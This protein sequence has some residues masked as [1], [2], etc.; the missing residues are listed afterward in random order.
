[1]N[2][3]PS[4]WEA[5]A[6]P[7][8]YFRKDKSILLSLPAVFNGRG[9]KVAAQGK[10]GL[11]LK[12][13]LLSLALLLIAASCRAQQTPPQI[14][15]VDAMP[16]IDPGT[17]PQTP[18]LSLDFLVGAWPRPAW[19][20]RPFRTLGSAETG[21]PALR[22]FQSNLVAMSPGGPANLGYLYCCSYAPRWNEALG[23][24]TVHVRVAFKSKVW[25]KNTKLNF[26]GELPSPFDTSPIASALPFEV[27]WEPLP[28]KGFPDAQL[29]SPHPYLW[30][31]WVHVFRHPA[32]ENQRYPYEA[33]VML[34]GRRAKKRQSTQSLG[35][36]LDEMGTE[37][38]I[39]QGGWGF[40]GG[41][42]NPDSNTGDFEFAENP[43]E[44]TLWR[45][46]WD[47]GVAN[48]NANEFL[49]QN[50]EYGDREPIV[51]TVPVKR[52]GV[53]L[54]G[55]IPPHDWKIEPPSPA[56]N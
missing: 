15:I 40:M 37:V 14:R 39:Q 20:G 5:D 50:I 23:L 1:M 17:I 31:K 18:L 16:T 54:E 33:E 4:A 6:L 53:T 10:I 51:L 11:M 9:K 55:D 19:W 27:Q 38:V 12:P 21:L 7:L 26:R 42:H 45:M 22:D 43:L 41:F 49:Q 46:G 56:S 29:I 25:P 36:F 24:Y 52:D 8:S 28:K 3:R 48:A 30:V 47:E 34:T 13:V 2:P 32:S 35:R 44:F